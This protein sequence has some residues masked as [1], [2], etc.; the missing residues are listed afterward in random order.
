MSTLENGSPVCFEC[1]A[2]EE[3]KQKRGEQKSSNIK[4]FNA[5][6]RNEEKT[7]TW[8]DENVV[9]KRQVLFLGLLV[10]FIVICFVVGLTDFSTNE[11]ESTSI[12]EKLESRASITA[13]IHYSSNYDT[14]NLE[15]KVASVRQVGENWRVAGKVFATDEY[16]DTYSANWSITYSQDLL[17]IESEYGKPTKDR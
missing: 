6:S 5:T 1:V 11:T 17:Q 9:K 15:I 4:E 12:E 14:I 3:K 8:L 13:K 2:E 10:V 16:G 7:L